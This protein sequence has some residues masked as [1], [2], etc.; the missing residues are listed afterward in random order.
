MSA[1]SYRPDLQQ[2]AKQLYKFGSWAACQVLAIEPVARGELANLLLSFPIWFGNIYNIFLQKKFKEFP[3][4]TRLL[5]PTSLC[6][7]FFTSCAC[8]FRFWKQVWKSLH[9]SRNVFACPWTKFSS[10]RETVVLASCILIFLNLFCIP[11][12]QSSFTSRSCIS[13]TPW[14]SGKTRACTCCGCPT[15]AGFWTCR[16]WWRSDDPR[17]SQGEPWQQLSLSWHVYWLPSLSP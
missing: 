10:L 11:F 13:W 3:L 7:S 5:W 9:V 1:V 15:H 16:S 6:M 12:N 17:R 8:V 14:T 2:S 4:A